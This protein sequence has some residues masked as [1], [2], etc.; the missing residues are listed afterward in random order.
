MVDELDA[1]KFLDILDL[2][3]GG[4]LISDDAEMACEVVI[5]D[6][7]SESGFSGTRDAGEGHEDAEGKI[8][9]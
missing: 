6:G 7:V 4:C 1:I 5:N 8:K 2:S 9:I 3:S